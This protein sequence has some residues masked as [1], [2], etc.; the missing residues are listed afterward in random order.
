M[1]Q[2][3]RSF[4]IA[5]KKGALGEQIVK[6]YLEEKGWVV[7]CPFTKDKAHYFDML[8]TYTK[9]KVVAFDI[10]TKARLNKWNA[11][12]IDKKHYDQYMMFIE[13][14]N[15]PFWLIFIDDKNGNVHALELEK[16]KNGFTPGSATHIIAW[17]I[18]NMTYLFNI[19]NENITK[20]SEFDQRNYTYNPQTTLEING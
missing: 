6:D 13:K 17:E 14:T 20:L 5:L 1:E 19:G 12:G 18:P 3:H 9:E 16:A 11:Q 8:A 10:K 4:E 2:K 15:V 7:Y